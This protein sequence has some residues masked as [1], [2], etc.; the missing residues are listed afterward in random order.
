MTALHKN[1]KRLDFSRPNA[2][3]LASIHTRDMIHVQVL[4]ALTEPD[5][6]STSAGM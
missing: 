5:S 6:K 4:V 1:R 2:L 3:M